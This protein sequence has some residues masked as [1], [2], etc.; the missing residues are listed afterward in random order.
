VTHRFTNRIAGWMILAFASTAFLVSQ[1]NAAVPGAVPPNAAKSKPESPPF[2]KTYDVLSL[3]WWLWDFMQAAP[4]NPTFGNGACTSGQSG[5][6]WF[7]YGLI[8]PASSVTCVIPGGKSLFLPIVNTECSSLEPFP[9][10]GDTAHERQACADAWMDHVS[11]LAL[12]IDGKSVQNLA[13]LRTRSG[14]FSFTVP[15]NSILGVPG[16]AWGFSSADGYYALLSPLSAGVH[17]IQIK[18]TIKDPF[19]PMHPVVGTIDTTLTLL[20]GH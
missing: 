7:L 16:P 5:D 2:G 3:E 6:V 17:T 4:V 12:K 9:F 20:I 19:D 15:D 14:D 18:A 10:H 8:G 11:G 1:L 13:P